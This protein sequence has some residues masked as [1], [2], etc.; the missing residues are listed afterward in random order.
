MTGHGRLAAGARGNLVL[1][2]GDPF[3]L[4]SHAI[5]VFIDGKDLDLRTRQTEL[6]ERWRMLP[7]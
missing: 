6:F 4:S 7:R 1:W 2:S 5:K 3:E